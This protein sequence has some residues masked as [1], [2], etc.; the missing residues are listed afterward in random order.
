MK[1]F[2]VLTTPQ[3]LSSLPSKYKLEKNKNMHHFQQLTQHRMNNHSSIVTSR[4]L[5]TTTQERVLLN[6]T[7]SINNHK[8]RTCHFQEGPQ[9]SKREHSE[10]WQLFCGLPLFKRVHMI[11]FKIPFG[12][13]RTKSKIVLNV[14]TGPSTS[15]THFSI[16]TTCFLC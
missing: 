8:Q 14:E 3:L 11:S 13:N 9:K 2:Q 5:C 12:G 10:Q 6:T 4:Y 16:S 1:K 15:N 7:F